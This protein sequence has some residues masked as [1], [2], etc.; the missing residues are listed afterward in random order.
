MTSTT[1]APGQPGAH[2]LAG[3]RPRLRRHLAPL[4]LL[5]IG[6][7]FLAAACS[8]DS[9]DASTPAEAM[10]FNESAEPM[11][12]T[13]VTAAKTAMEMD[14]ESAEPAPDFELVLFQTE[15]HTA[16]ETLRLSELRGRPVVVNFWFPSCPPCR[17]EMP[18]LEK[19]FQAHRA[20]GVEFVGVMLLGLDTAQDGQDFIDEIGANFAFGADEE[21]I[22][23]AYKIRGFPSTMFIDENGNFVRKWTGALNEEKLEEFV[24]ELLK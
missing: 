10:A 2:I 13:E 11:D 24:Q 19:V 20:D 23:R 4:I 5:L 22:T 21:D 6:A 17:Q 15:L 12:E 14:D 9:D 16:G 18:D 8:S 3:L 7:A 1:G